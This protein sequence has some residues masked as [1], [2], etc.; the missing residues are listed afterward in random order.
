MLLSFYQN[1]TPNIGGQ[2]ENLYL[3]IEPI[4][5]ERIHER[6]G[7]EKIVN[8]QDNVVTTQG[9]RFKNNGNNLTGGRYL[10]T[11]PDG[12]IV[13]G[14][15]YT[16]INR[17]VVLSNIYVRIDFRRQGIATALI[18]AATTDFPR[19]TLD[20]SL[21]EKGASLFGYTP[22]HTTHSVIKP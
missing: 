21:T 3:Y 7:T 10:F 12:S 11:A 17:D 4:D 5:S 8:L 19:L 14:L 6:I 1:E 2:G 20:S 13:G 22:T 9:Q 16:K 15:N 18:K